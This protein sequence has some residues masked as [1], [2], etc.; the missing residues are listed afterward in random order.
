MKITLS[1]ALKL[2]N[3][4]ASIINKL[5]N[6]V[7]QS[8]SYN[9]ENKP[10]YNSQEQYNLYEKEVELM[11]NLKSVINKANIEIIPTILEL[12]E[13][14]AKISMLNQLNT[15]NEISSRGFGDSKVVVKY[16]A[17][18]NEESKDQMINSLESKV[19]ELQDKIDYY[20]TTTEIEF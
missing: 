13:T 11:N 14:K 5:R 2:K 16:I 3:K 10:T 8:N 18:I 9:E 19:E 6:R 7:L 12:G 17:T 1:K 20:N 15:I 4:R